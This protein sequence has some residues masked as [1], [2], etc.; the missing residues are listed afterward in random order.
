MFSD[1]HMQISMAAGTEKRR[2]NIF[3]HKKYKHKAWT[4]GSI[5]LYLFKAQ[6]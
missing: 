1:K 3:N 4:E 5:R 6:P 2:N